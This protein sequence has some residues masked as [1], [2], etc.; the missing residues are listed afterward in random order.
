[1][2]LDWSKNDEPGDSRSRDISRNCGQLL[3][4]LEE[5]LPCLY[6]AHYGASAQELRERRRLMPRASS[7]LVSAREGTI[8]AS[9]C[10]LV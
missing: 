5:L 2:K 4:S 8:L 10:V 9:H 1:M 6:I 3:G 7:P